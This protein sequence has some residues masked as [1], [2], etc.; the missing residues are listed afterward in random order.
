MN[1]SWNW[2]AFPPD[3][4]EAIAYELGLKLLVVNYAEA[5]SMWFGETPKNIVA[6]FR[7]AAEQNA[8]LL[9][10]EADAIAMRRSSGAGLPWPLV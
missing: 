5:E 3:S 10:D 1:T 6:T 2:P 7:A 4:A 8:V 9:F